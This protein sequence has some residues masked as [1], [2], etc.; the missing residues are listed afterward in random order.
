MEPRDGSAL[1][2]RAL[3][4]RRAVVRQLGGGVALAALA[5]AGVFGRTLA[6]EA[7]PEAGEGLAG[8]YAVIRLRKVKPNRSPEELAALVRE[9]FLPLVREVPGFVAY[10]VVANAETRAWAAVGVFADKAGAD[11]STA[12]AA[13]WGQ[14][15]AN[16]FVEGDPVV[17]EGE[18]AVAA[19]EDG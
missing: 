5:G 6:Q 3:A 18:I 17:I 4:N 19:G 10:F 11:E 9:G 14:G 8:R 12:R 1:R 13:E 15:G 16:D 7:T 2:E